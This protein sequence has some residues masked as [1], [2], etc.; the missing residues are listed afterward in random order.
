M[1]AQV[2]ALI[3][4]AKERRRRAP[5]TFRQTDITRALKAAL[6]AGFGQVRVEIDKDGKIAIV[7]GNNAEG[8]G[9]PTNEWD[10]VK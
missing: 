3:D 5:C 8:V 1:P 4:R 6:A 10:G 9:T 7:A 2:A